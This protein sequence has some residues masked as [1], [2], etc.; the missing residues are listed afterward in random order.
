[1][2]KSSMFRK[3]MHGHHHHVP[4]AVAAATARETSELEKRLKKN[5]REQKRCVRTGVGV[6]GD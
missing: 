1:M 4:A 2:R 5:A 6:V 3:K